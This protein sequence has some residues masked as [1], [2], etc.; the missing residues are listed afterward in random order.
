MA[1]VEERRLDGR[2]GASAFGLAK[3]ERAGPGAIEDDRRRDPSSIAGPLIVA[4]DEDA[5]LV[6]DGEA[7]AHR[8]TLQLGRHQRQVGGAD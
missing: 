8:R 4:L 2:A 7:A 5:S 3:R 6:D 1:V